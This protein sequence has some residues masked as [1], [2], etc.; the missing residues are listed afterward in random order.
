MFQR[1]LISVSDKTNIDN[2]ANFLAKKG[3]EILSTGGTASFLKSKGIKVIDVSE[4][5]GFPEIMDGRVKT[6]H[7]K[8]HGGI[9]CI[10]N[11]KEH[12][13]SLQKLGIPFI[14]IVV[15][16][17]YP[18]EAT[19]K[20]SNVTFEEVIEN[21]DIGGP[22]LIRASAKNFQDVVVVVDP[23]DYEKVMEYIE[24][25]EVPYD[26]RFYLAKKVYTHTA[27]YDGVI[28]SYL[29]SIEKDGKKAF[30]E[31]INLQYFKVQECRYGENPHQKAAF[32]REKEVNFACVSSAKKI[33]GKELSYNNILDT[34]SC[35]R[36]VMEFSEPAAVIVK[37]NNPC[38]AA[39]NE[40]IV[41]AYKMARDCDPVSAFGGIVALNRKVN[42]ELAKEVAETFV[43]VVIAPGYDGEAL[44]IFA[45]HPSLRV[46]DV[47]GL[48][49]KI[50][51]VEYRRVLGGM[52]VQEY[53]L[54][55]YKKEDLK[56][57]TKRKPTEEEMK[58]LD[59][60]WKIAKH[61]KSNAI[62][63]A[64][65]NVTVGVGAG[66]MSRVDSARIAVMKARQSTKG[67]V[68]ASDAFFPFPDGLEV[69]AEAGITAVIQP[70]GSI[71]D[72]EV[73]ELADK[74][75]MAMV[76][77]GMRHFKH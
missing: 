17:L 56:V 12:V 37:H 69:L 9:L 51:G 45:K 59:F 20:K 3:I 42:G 40:N 39:I 47:E 34:D 49:M 60:A 74:Y 63:I 38:G 77:T 11:K 75:N 10:R 43:E 13:E 71:R 53:D 57:V 28:S 73:I 35:F 67:C 22:T 21:I 33:Q 70:G 64:K 26:Y 6:L 4:Y 68:A 55:T 72:K 18:F 54:E 76:F 61:V 7:P 31:V 15:V 58:A 27:H 36:I 5:T 24:Q 23:A 48:P 52:L 50:E 62:L 32:Y 29:S 30:P 1:A 46:L 41:E 65:E 19:I 2:F 14:D 44:E 16:N 8:I 66:Q 25:G